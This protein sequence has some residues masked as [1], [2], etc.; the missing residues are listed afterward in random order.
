MLNGNAIESAFHIGIKLGNNAAD[1]RQ[2]LAL[3]VEWV[4]SVHTLLEAHTRLLV[5]LSLH[6]VRTLDVTIRVLNHNPVVEHLDNALDGAF[7]FRQDAGVLGA[8]HL[9]KRLHIG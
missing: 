6:G 2:Y 4:S 3:G 7:A 5:L 9:E 8:P 1:I